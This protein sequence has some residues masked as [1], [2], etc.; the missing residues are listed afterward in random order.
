MS[1]SDPRY[2]G[3]NPLGY[4]FSR[5]Q[6]ISPSFPPKTQMDQVL[7]TVFTN[8]SP[9]V[10]EITMPEEQKKELQQKI[11]SVASDIGSKILTAAVDTVSLAAENYVSNM[12]TSPKNISKSLSERLFQSEDESDAFVTKE[13]MIQTNRSSIELDDIEEDYSPPIRQII[14][15]I[16]SSPIGDSNDVVENEIKSEIKSEIMNEI[17]TEITSEI[18]SEIASEIASEIVSEITNEITNETTDETTDEPTNK[19]IIESDDSEDEIKFKDPVANLNPLYAAKDKICQKLKSGSLSERFTIMSNVAQMIKKNKLKILT[20][21]NTQC[22]KSSTIK[23]VFNITDSTLVI[24]NNTKSETAKIT[25]Y[26]YVQNG[27]TLTVVDVPGFYDTDGRSDLFYNMI[28]NYIKK[29]NGH[30]ST[31]IDVI[32]WISKIDDVVAAYTQAIINKL[33]CDLG[34]HFWKKTM[35]VLTH[36]N[37]TA[38]IP[39]NYYNMFSTK[40]GLE[41]YDTKVEQEAWKLHTQNKINIWKNAFKLYNADINVLLVE[42]NRRLNGLLKGDI[43]KL[44]DGTPIIETIYAKT[45]ELIEL[46]SAPAMFTFLIGNTNMENDVDSDLSPI[47]TPDST[48]FSINDDNFN[49]AHSSLSS[50]NFHDLDYGTVEL[51]SKPNPKPTIRLTGSRSPCPRK[52]T[53]KNKDSFSLFPDEKSEHQKALDA[54]APQIADKVETH[55]KE[56]NWFER[57]C[58]IF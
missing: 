42:N 3:W 11:A 18:T 33:T 45:F 51:N 41:E 1:G 49:S 24:G 39:D 48:G 13:K 7:N 40:L 54:V 28:V 14:S 20:L 15:D 12:N 50:F 8:L 29:S 35:I 38:S 37:S 23:Y 31:K 25:E 46:H 5:P 21:G 9:I 19:I 26:P 57:N 56:K 27:I 53:K 34:N 2:N 43:G 16:V 6:A 4:M 58:T 30:E 10:N 36:S 55:I 17:T 44:L 47:G 22:G 32:L 52:N